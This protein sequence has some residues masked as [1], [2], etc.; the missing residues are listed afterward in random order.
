MIKNTNQGRQKLRHYHKYGIVQCSLFVWF[1]PYPEA[2]MPLIQTLIY[3]NKYIYGLMRKAAREIMCRI[4]KKIYFLD[5][6]LVKFMSIVISSLHRSNA[7]ET[8]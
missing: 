7:N 2:H 1:C 6:F 5:Y 8:K 4:Y 3:M